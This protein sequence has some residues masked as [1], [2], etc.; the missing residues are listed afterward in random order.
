[1]PL[2]HDDCITVTRVHQL[3]FA[4]LT[5]IMSSHNH[6]LELN[7]WVLG[8]ET[9][10]VFPVTILND[11]SVGILKGAI[12]GETNSQFGD[13]AADTLDLYKTSVAEHEINTKLA[14]ID[15]DYLN[16]LVPLQ[17]IHKLSQVFSDP[18]LF[19]TTIYISLL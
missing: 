6:L 15:L 11:G 13:I 2:T 19:P 3:N 10:R 17:S 4:G 7:C 14:E 16:K 12:K 1:V 9:W 18:G 8:N 5:N